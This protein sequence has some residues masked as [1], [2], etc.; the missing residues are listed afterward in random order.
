MRCCNQRSSGA[1]TVSSE[2]TAIAKTTTISSKVHSR[3]FFLRG[4]AMK[5]RAGRSRPARCSMLLL[6]GTHTLHHLTHVHLLVARGDL[7]QACRR[8]SLFDVGQG[9]G[10]VIADRLDR[11]LQRL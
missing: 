5:N 8:L 11:K 7:E 9:K 2:T 1:G 6:R 4:A 3:I 10:L